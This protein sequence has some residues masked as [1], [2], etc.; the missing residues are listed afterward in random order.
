MTTSEIQVYEGNG[1][2]PEEIFKGFKQLHALAVSMGLTLIVDHDHKLRVNIPMGHR[3]RYS[4]FYEEAKKLCLH[5][6][7]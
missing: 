6:Y 5:T 3:D 4:K 2:D 1:D 7:L